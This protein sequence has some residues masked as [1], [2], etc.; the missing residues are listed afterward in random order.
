MCLLNTAQYFIKLFL[1]IK[2]SDIWKVALCMYPIIS[3]PKR[4]DVLFA[5]ELIINV[6][7]LSFGRKLLWS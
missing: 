7:K 2:I 3:D 5:L 4:R 1:I 6:I